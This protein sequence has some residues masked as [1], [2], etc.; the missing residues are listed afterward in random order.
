M[1]EINRIVEVINTH[2]GSR[3]SDPA[4]HTVLVGTKVT[5]ADLI[6]VVWHDVL[7]QVFSKFPER[8]DI[9]K[10]PKYK[11]WIEGMQERPSVQK[12]RQSQQDIIARMQ[13][14]EFQ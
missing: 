4:P 2:L 10:F 8:W 1:T 11:Q 14:G 3:T 9:N 12:A 6:F 13:K 5:Y 7:A